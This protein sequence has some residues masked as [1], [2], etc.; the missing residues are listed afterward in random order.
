MTYQ[1]VQPAQPHED[2][3]RGTVVALLTIPA[4]IIVFV[5]VWSIGFIASA[6]TLGV[7]YL[8]RFLYV[9][10]SGGVISRVGAIRVTFITIA[11]V[12][13]SI[14]AGLIA[15][16][17]IGISLVSSLSPIEA[18][19]D[20]R[21]SQVF[22]GYL[23]ESDPQFS[24]WPRI[25]IALAFGALGCFSLLRAT[26]RATAAPVVN[27]ATGQP[28]SQSPITPGQPQQLWPQ[29]PTIPPTEDTPPR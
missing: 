4:G 25:L 2:V 12:L 8:A 6:V 9:L 19:T 1:P 18:L 21:F 15:D 13:L 10:G 26:L 28:W 3:N 24:P 29:N 27:P 20:P 7:A 14:V 22:N 23:T 16:V 11:T 17:A 5:L